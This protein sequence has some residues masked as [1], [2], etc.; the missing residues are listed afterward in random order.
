MAVEAL[1]VIPGPKIEQPQPQNRFGVWAGQ[2]S[3]LSRLT[4]EYSPSLDLYMQNLPNAYSSS[5]SEQRLKL[6]KKARFAYAL[7]KIIDQK[8]PILAKYESLNGP[9]VFTNRIDK[10]KESESYQAFENMQQKWVARIERKFQEKSRPAKELTRQKLTAE[11]IK[12]KEIFDDLITH[13]LRL[14]IAINRDVF[15]Q[16]TMPIPD[17]LQEGNIGLIKALRKFDPRL[18]FKFSTYAFWNIK[19][20]IKRAIEN[21]E[22]IIRLP[23]HLAKPAYHIESTRKKLLKALERHPSIAEVA[24][25]TDKKPELVS[26]IIRSKYILSLN[27]PARNLTELGDSVSTEENPTERLALKTLQAQSV[28]K[29]LLTLDPRSRLIIAEYFGLGDTKPKTLKEIA[30]KHGLSEVRIGQLK[31]RAILQLQGTHAQS[32][33]D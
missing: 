25:A 19:Q 12:G 27:Q 5:E 23:I 22:G 15:G 14:V 3:N 13:N 2:R 28:Q 30:R 6:L 24:E 4:S 16:S 21:K 10:E 8:N 20:A 29:M 26:I 11:I 31:K 32:L 33:S 1:K 9:T 17:R 7:L 18:G